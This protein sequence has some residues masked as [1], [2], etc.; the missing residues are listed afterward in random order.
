MGKTI[1]AVVSLLLVSGCGSP[2]ANHDSA[3]KSAT[4][5]VSAAPQ[6]TLPTPQYSV[7]G[8][9]S[10]RRDGQP[11]YYV[12]IDPVDLSNDGFK[13]NVKL[14]AQALAQKKGDA[15][16]TVRFFD[17]QDIAA[18]S[19]QSDPGGPGSS[20]DQTQAEMKDFL[21]RKGQH[22]V[23]IYGGGL[24]AALY[25]YELNWYPAAFTST[26]NVGPYV[27]NEEWKPQI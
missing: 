23:A 27:G 7:A 19:Y 5:S 1:V 8:Q 13:R 12:V 16:F 10:W 21:D 9:S 24:P 17:D 25:P 4:S 11:S 14:V 20:S 2:S 26:P 6:S 18:E 3:T 22:L 15:D